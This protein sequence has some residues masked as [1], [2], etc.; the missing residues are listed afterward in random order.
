MTNTN[1]MR[2][3][4]LFSSAAVTFA[5]LV[6]AGSVFG[7]AEAAL[8]FG[9]FLMGL[10]FKNNQIKLLGGGMTIEITKL[11]KV[12]FN[13]DGKIQISDFHFEA[14]YFVAMEDCGI[15]AAKFVIEKLQS[16]IEELE[17]I[18][19]ERKKHWYT[20]SIRLF[21]SEPPVEGFEL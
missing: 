9:S 14:D 17:A 16:A 18:S 4:L 20:D 12:T 21:G 19:V 1:R 6:Y 2:K 15:V 11:G 8:C 3:F 13:E 10:V 5:N 7:H